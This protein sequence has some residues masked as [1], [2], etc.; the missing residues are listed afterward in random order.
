[1]TELEDQIQALERRIAEA[2]GQTPSTDATYVEVEQPPH[3]HALSERGEL[4]DQLEQWDPQDPL[5]TSLR[6]TLCVHRLS[7]VRRLSR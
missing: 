2:A 1:M 5:P 6:S 3:P 7:A 4:C